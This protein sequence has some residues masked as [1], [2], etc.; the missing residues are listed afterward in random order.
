MPNSEQ[1]FDEFKLPAIPTS[2]A[3]S[4]LDEYWNQL[5]AVK[6]R[7]AE[8]AYNKLGITDNPKRELLFIAAVDVVTERDMIDF[9]EVYRYMKSFLILIIT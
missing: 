9:R 6:H 5:T 2:L 8:A 3:T 7:F 4:A 1:W